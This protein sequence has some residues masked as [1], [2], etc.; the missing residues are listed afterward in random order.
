M[1]TNVHLWKYT[2]QFARL[3]DLKA[4]HE[5]AE[6]LQWTVWYFIYL[7]STTKT[8]ISMYI[9][10]KAMYLVSIVST[11]IAEACIKCNLRAMRIAEDVKWFLE[12]YHMDDNDDD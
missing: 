12:E 7:L 11:N 5:L 2:Q 10:I 3:N 4:D 9:I 6:G 1:K 8:F